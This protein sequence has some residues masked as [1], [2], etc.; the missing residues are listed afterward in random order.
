[1][2]CGF[3][4]GADESGGVRKLRVGE[5]R[6]ERTDSRVAIFAKATAAREGVDW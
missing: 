2:D 3:G 6:S 5:W 4:D 1:M